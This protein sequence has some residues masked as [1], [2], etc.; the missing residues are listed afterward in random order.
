MVS[1]ACHKKSLAPSV[2]GVR[3]LYR[4]IQTA[5]TVLYETSAEVTNYVIAFCE[6]MCKPGATEIEF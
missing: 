4:A 3:F 1:A 6:T 5:Q 2:I